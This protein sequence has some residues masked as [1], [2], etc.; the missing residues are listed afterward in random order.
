MDAINNYLCYKALEW[1]HPNW[2][3]YKSNWSE[4]QTLEGPKTLPMILDTCYQMFWPCHGNNT[5]NS[6][7]VCNIW[8]NMSEEHISKSYR[9]SLAKFV[10]MFEHQIG[11]IICK[12][13][14]NEIKLKKDYSMK[15]R[16]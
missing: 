1:P 10:S 3:K 14:W 4:F 8:M 16:G 9:K 6:K 15:S 11:N 2:W 7:N 12:N 13:L 5:I